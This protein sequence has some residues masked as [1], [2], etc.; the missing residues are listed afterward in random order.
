MSSRWARAVA[1]FT[2]GVPVQAEEAAAPTDEA[3]AP[4]RRDPAPPR[5]PSASSPASSSTP[6][7]PVSAQELSRPLNP[8]GD[9]VF[10]VVFGGSS[11]GW[12][13]GDELAG[14][15]LDRYAHEGG[16]LVDVADSY[17]S[18][19]SEVMLGSWLRRRNAAGR[20]LVST[21]VGRHP[22]APGLGPVSLV[23]AVEAS[24]TRLG[25]DR[26]NQLYLHVDDSATRL[27]DVL[28]TVGWLIDS[29]KVGSLGVTS[30]SAERLVEARVLAGAGYPLI[31]SLQLH[32]SLLTRDA[33]DG[34]TGL[35]A[36]AQGLSVL[37]YFSLES[38]FLS[39]RYRQRQDLTASV[40]STRAGAHLNRRGLRV[41]RALDRVADEHGVAPATAALAWVLGRQGITG[42]IV[43]SSSVR[44]L[45]EAMA[46]ARLELSPRGRAALDVAASGSSGRRRLP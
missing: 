14:A 37:S 28:G 5:V 9:R 2:A 35:V 11:F 33:F 15:L 24:L 36:R 4:A 20:F 27:E 40:R 31:T 42:A 44:Q 16:N 29:G 6:G 41:L 26:I 1:P 46:A 17:A 30:Y 21:K 18:G 7:E 45:D 22:D 13:I 32:Y 34:D 38:G 19:R 8:S 23:R 39:G 25:V 3:A 43:G 12:T 10:P